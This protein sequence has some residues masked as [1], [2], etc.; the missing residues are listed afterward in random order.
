MI[1]FSKRVILSAAAASLMALALTGCGGD[2]KDGAGAASP[3]S[4]TATVGV[5]GGTVNG[6][7]GVQVVIPAGALSKPTVIG[8]ARSAVGAPTTLPEDYPATAATPIYE[9]T[10]HDVVFNKPVTIRIATSSNAPNAQIFMA[11]PGEE[12]Q[13]SD[14]RI[15]SDFAEWQR[16]S[17]SWGFFPFVCSP[18]N[19]APYSSSN[20]DPYPCS[21]PSGY[22]SASATPTA[23]ITKVTTGVLDTFLGSAGSWTVNQA[24][25][26]RLTINYQ[27][28][29]DCQNPR[30]KLIRRS[31]T[32]Q[33]TLGPKQTLSDGPVSLTPTN[34]TNP[35]AFGGGTYVRGV[36]SASYEVAFSHLDN[37]MTAFGYTFSCNRPN[38]PTHTG[39]DSLT[40]VASIPVPTVTYTVGGT[41]SGLTGTG[42]VL[43]NNVG[44]NLAVAANGVISF[45]TPVG[46]GAPYAVSVL[47]QPVGQTCSVQNGS[48]TAN[49]A[50]SNVAV[51]CIPTFTVGG[52]V[53]GLVGTGLVL[54]NNGADNLAFTTSGAFAFATR[55]ASA[56]RYNVTV[57]T[58]PSGSTCSVANGG[59][60]IASANIANV[61]VTCASSG[62]LALVANS[63]VRNGV[64][65][66]SIYR[67]NP[68]TGV[69]SFLNNVNAGDTPW[70]V[71]VSPNGLYA[72]VTNAVGGTISS[73]AI[74]NS[75]GAVTLIPLSSPQSLNS[76]GVAM[77]RLG[78]F[79]WTTN[80]GFS[81]VSAFSIGTNGVL[82]A[83]GSPLPTPY[84]L[85]YVIAAHP[86]MDVVYVAHQSNF[87]VSVYS[88]NTTN[89][90]LTLQQTLTNVITAANGLVIHPTG[91]FAYVVSGSGGVCALTINPS[92]GNL[93]IGACATPPGGGGTFSV[94]IHPNGQYLY[95]TNDS[96]LNNVAVFSINQTTGALTQVGSPVTA[97]A[98]PR[99]VAVGPGGNYLYVTSYVGNSVE[100]FSIGAG[101][102]SLTSLGAS[103][104][105]G[106]GSLPVG[107]AVTP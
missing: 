105:T 61:A 36:G 65:G 42:L 54:Q 60:S 102:G 11:S 78:R 40:F 81:T 101:G 32:P 39:G 48:G 23:A 106:N 107:I 33:G 84:T 10:P 76:Y 59:G 85:P 5:E 15:S 53:N 71:A 89:G 6:P 90:T 55:L 57:L 49:A 4:T 94:T 7:D 38:R 17:F 80:Y 9:F 47:T 77:D 98:N 64:N 18:V 66:V 88:V 69:L 8:I 73:Y 63:G 29:P 20:P 21:I 74:N 26:V 87:A 79:I 56:A 72:Y 45:A 25:I 19:I 95:T 91:R 52:N 30:V 93:S 35:Y 41:V 37:G 50:V 3:A 104:G 75:M 58:Q 86:T 44:D 43:Q 46:G 34:L 67:A 16:N 14:A 31:P 13:A 68:T 96:T 103:N 100:G 82:T 70:A 22:V 24:S 99:G 92:S 62:P 83:A 27:A 12:W 51:T 28:A 97:S 2:V 1:E